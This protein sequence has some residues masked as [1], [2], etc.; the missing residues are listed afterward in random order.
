MR[1]C[2]IHRFIQLAIAGHCGIVPENNTRDYAIA[3]H[4]TISVPIFLSEAK[5]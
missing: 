1:H 5:P 4:I 3:H 2:F